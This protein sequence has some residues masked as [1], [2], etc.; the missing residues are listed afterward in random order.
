MKP[1]TPHRVLAEKLCKKFPDTPSR[2]L[3]KRVSAECK[4]NIEM[5]RTAVR[6]VRGVN[7]SDRRGHTQDKSLFKQP[8]KAGAKP[9]LPPSLAK[10]WEPFE[11]GG[12]ITVGVISDLHIPYHDEQAIQ[13][14]VA[15]LRRRKPDVL[16][17]NGD[18]GD[19]YSVSRY[20]KDPKKRRL[21]RE[22]RMQRDG[23]KWLRSQFPKARIVA[24][25]GNHEL[26]WSHFLFNSAPEV[27][28]F[29][30]V[31]LPRILGMKTLGIEYV[32]NQRPIMAGK[33]PVFH[34][35]EL[36]K[37][38]SSPVNASR[39]V[40]T[41]MISTALVGHHHRTSSH[42]E[43]NWKHEEI[44]CW[45]TG[46]LCNLNA[47][48]AVINKWNAGFAVVEVDGSGQFQVDNLRLNTDYAVRSG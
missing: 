8:G 35:H 43:P 3:A 4:V 27:S 14:A 22:I 37:G 45:S 38:I 16:L 34:G 5:A 26:R 33:L 15:Y 32:D 24:K 19:W 31:S 13:A 12:G 30:Q 1:K 47:E 6:T 48:Y 42:T 28:E 25:E 41:R 23:L 11:L 10:K 21:K 9:K 2:T 40:F 36:G 39:G 7:G 17:I 18:Y 20:M 29:P 44:V 46:C